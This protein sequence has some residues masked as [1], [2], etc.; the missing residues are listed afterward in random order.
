MLLK[1]EI[2]P[3]ESLGVS[4]RQECCLLGILNISTIY[5]QGW[6]ARDDRAQ[7][8]RAC[9]VLIPKVPE[10]NGATSGAKSRGRIGG[11]T[12]PST[13]EQTD[14]D[15]SS[16]SRSDWIRQAC[17]A[18]LTWRKMGAEDGWQVLQGSFLSNKWTLEGG[19][20]NG[21]IIAIF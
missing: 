4:G 13:K 1:P 19:L 18:H 8:F 12:T 16:L 2:Q 10:Y 6:A 15:P 14:S 9:L 5:I 7:G 20:S 3:T 21:H 17:Y 11:H